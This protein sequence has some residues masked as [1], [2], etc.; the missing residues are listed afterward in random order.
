MRDMRIIKTLFDRTEKKR[1]V[2]Y[3]SYLLFVLLAFWMLYR[4]N[5]FK[6]AS[7]DDFFMTLPVSGA[8]GEYSVFNCFNS[9]IY[10]GILCGLFY[11]LPITNWV[12]VFNISTI[13]VFYVV[14]GI[15]LIRKSESTI[16]SVLLSC[17]VFLVSIPIFLNM[18]FTKTAGLATLTGVILFGEG[19]FEKCKISIKTICGCI[20]IVFGFMN[21]PK[22]ALLVLPFL[23]LYI[24]KTYTLEVIRLKKNVLIIL[25][26]LIICVLFA[27]KAICLQEKN[28]YFFNNYYERIS[29]LLDY[30]TPNCNDNLLEYSNLNVSQNDY[31]MLS[32]CYYSDTSF[33]THELLDSIAEMDKRSLI[34]KERLCAT[35]D[36]FRNEMVTYVPLI[37]GIAIALVL[38]AISQKMWMFIMVAGLS[39][40]E[41]AYLIYMG[42]YPLRV[43]CIPMICLVTFT[44]LLGMEDIA[45]I[46]RRNQL[47]FAMVVTIFSVLFGGALTLTKQDG[48]GYL[49]QETLNIL[50]E[51][52]SDSEHLYICDTDNSSLRIRMA[53]EPFDFMPFDSLKNIAFDE[54]WNVELPVNIT[55]VE[56]YIGDYNIYKHATDGK[57]LFLGN[58]YIEQKRQYIR[59]HYHSE[60]DYAIIRW[61]EGEPIIRFSENFVSYLT[62]NMLWKLSNFQRIE[63]YYGIDIIVDETSFDEAYLEI[64]GD[65][66]RYTYALSIEDGSGHT[67]IPA[68]SFDEGDVTMRLILL[69]NGTTYG[70][71]NT[72]IKHIGD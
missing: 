19:L 21:R 22:A 41:I 7:S 67:M 61:I 38:I 49:K 33:W 25:C 46:T 13:F 23:F 53:F 54:G 69:D 65:G 50:K 2:A 39:L 51:V 58:N 62:R 1:I 4:L 68:D 20:L 52:N 60:A 40:G 29:T 42:R 43:I 47:V 30:N 37:F 32:G 71:E 14:L 34:S 36:A 11:L 16:S 6:H 5:Y 28:M 64:S 10:G 44:L 56:S 70:S 48:Y 18:N 63:D 17:S 57:L 9:S 8:Y 3:I 72:F 15:M 12:T 27:D 66:I 24:I 26:I 59:E 35:F 45:R 31:A 55:K